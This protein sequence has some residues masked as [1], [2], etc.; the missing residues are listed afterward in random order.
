MITINRVFSPSRFEFEQYHMYFLP[1]ETIQQLEVPKPIY[2]VGTRGTGKTTLLKALN[3]EQRCNN[4]ILRNQIEG[5]PFAKKYIGVYFKAPS[6]QLGDL[7]AWLLNQ[8][9]LLAGSLFGFFV[10]L[11][12]LELL[13]V[14][15]SELT[16]TGVLQIQMA[17]ERKAVLNIVDAHRDLFSSIKDKQPETLL[18]LATAFRRMNHRLQRNAQIRRPVQESAATL[19]VG[20]VGCFGRTVGALLG[21][22]CS[23]PKTESGEKWYF[24]LCVD[25]AEYFSA[26]Q[27]LAFNTLVRMAEGP[28]CPVA[29]YVSIPEDHTGTLMNGLS[30]QTADRHLHL[31]DEIEDKQ[32]LALAEGV[33]GVRIAAVSE[34]KV[35][36]LQPFKLAPILGEWNLN[37]LLESRL[38]SSSD[39]GAAQLLQDAAIL[40]KTPFFDK[41][42]NTSARETDSNN[43]DEVQP[44]D[45]DELDFEET[46]LPIYQAYL[47]KRMG[48]KLPTPGEDRWKRRRQESAELRKRM[49]AAYLSLCKEFK[50]DVVYA[51]AHVVFKLSDKCTRDFL[52]QLD[53]IHA[54]SKKPLAEFVRGRI[55]YA[56][57]YASIHA[58]SRSKC[59]AVKS[60]MR[61]PAETFRLIDGM[62][63][64]TAA[65]QSG[66]ADLRHLRSS[67]RGVF[68]LDY[69][70]DRPENT[71]DLVR[72]IVD[73]AQAG[74]FRIR[75]TDNDTLQFRLHTSLAAFYQFSF[76]GAYYPTPIEWNDIR[77]LAYTKSDLAFEAAILRLCQRLQANE[78]EDP[79]QLVLG[80][81]VFDYA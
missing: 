64:V 26:R 71:S 25:E 22:L 37:G 21:E 39:G 32:F 72:L 28:W 54:D 35:D 66:S 63:R 44:E 7:D 55:P 6:F 61:Y 34:P 16:V 40:A 67:E 43:V 60:G 51:S 58:A 4:S 11:I 2:L 18:E 23:G 1:K 80:T 17:D 24:K 46:A 62:A 30:L 8:T 78:S 31:L 10:D 65:I 36:L 74:F 3:W 20:Q 5:H 56:Q 76:R 57:Q 70:K 50:L 42:I 77:C 9:D 38:R 53:A 81:G 19:P 33:A 75:P 13:A 41:A 12:W 15:I 14:A 49:V 47:I 68:T 45:L 48:I 73:A 27:Q 52:V 59:D 29:S 69:R 79:N